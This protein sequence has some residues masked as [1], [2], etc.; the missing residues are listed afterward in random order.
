MLICVYVHVCA[1]ACVCICMCAHVCMHRHVCVHECSAGTSWSTTV[2]WEVITPWWPLLS[3]SLPVRSVA[4]LQVINGLPGEGVSESPGYSEASVSFSRSVGRVWLCWRRVRHS[5]Q[6]CRGSH[7]GAVGCLGLQVIEGDKFSKEAAFLV[8][9]LHTAQ[10]EVG[11]ASLQNEPQVDCKSS[12]VYCKW[13]VGVKHR[14]PADHLPCP[15]HPWGLVPQATHESDG[16]H[17]HPPGAA[18]LQVGGPES[19][20]PRCRRGR[21]PVPMGGDILQQPP[22]PWPAKATQWGP[23]QPCPQGP[24]PWVGHLRR[25]CPGLPARS[26]LSDGLVFTF[27]TWPCCRFL[28]CVKPFGLPTSECEMTPLL[29]RLAQ[30][31]YSGRYQ[32][33]HPRGFW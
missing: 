5:C 24:V 29:P 16:P 4:A 14:L 1:S 33:F 13:P 18:H 25:C 20:R 19:G 9:S 22:C 15:V 11:L 27:S 23:V 7:L 2:L 12:H 8:A 32:L 28:P 17:G 3:L 30:P 10:L 6:C 26:D 21:T 31:I